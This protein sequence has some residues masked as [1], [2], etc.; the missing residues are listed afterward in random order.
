MKNQPPGASDDEAKGRQLQLGGIIKKYQ[1]FHD[2]WGF[3]LGKQK[4]KIF[5]KTLW[6]MNP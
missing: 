4:P 6:F 5:R 3:V 1:K 2:Y